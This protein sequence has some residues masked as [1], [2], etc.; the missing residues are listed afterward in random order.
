LTQ[1]V[2]QQRRLAST[3]RTE[4]ENATRTRR[5]GQK[6][7]MTCREAPAPQP[8]RRRPGEEG[9]GERDKERREHFVASQDA[10]ATTKSLEEG[11]ERDATRSREL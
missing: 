9:A 2:A 11:D 4:D 1:R 10:G 6:R 3:R 8:V 7:L 5:L